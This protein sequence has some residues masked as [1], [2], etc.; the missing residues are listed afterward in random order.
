MPAPVILRV[1]FAPGNAP[2]R[3]PQNATMEN[4]TTARVSYPVD[5][6]FPGSK[7]FTAV[8]DFGSRRITRITLDPQNRFPDHDP[9]D[10]VW[11]RTPASATR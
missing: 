4:P 9:S 3:T 1:E 6:W 5:V 10:N 8:L 11:P 7:T 2:I